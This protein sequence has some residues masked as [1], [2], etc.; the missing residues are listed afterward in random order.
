M[1][2]TK[3]TPETIATLKKISK[4]VISFFKNVMI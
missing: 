2:I 4:G 1:R 3:V